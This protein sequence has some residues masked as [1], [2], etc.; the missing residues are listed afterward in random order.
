MLLEQAVSR[1]IDGPVRLKNQLIRLDSI[2][3][4]K[5][6]QAWEGRLSGS[7]SVTLL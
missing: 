2:L 1:L 4:A 5:P 3:D 6:V 7:R